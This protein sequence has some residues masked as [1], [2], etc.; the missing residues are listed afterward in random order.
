[1]VPATEVVQVTVP[2]IRD[3]TVIV[4][5][6]LGQT[7]TVAPINRP[8]IC[9]A[10]SP[11]PEIGPSDIGPSLIGMAIVPTPASTRPIPN[12][13]QRSLPP[14]RPLPAGQMSCRPVRLR[15]R[16]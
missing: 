10:G 13:F 15:R 12:Q 3:E 4:P 16:T 6:I 9:S 2:S 5:R 8:T 11:S 7:F 14:S 1:M